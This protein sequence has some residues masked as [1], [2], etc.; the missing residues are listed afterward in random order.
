MIFN[1]RRIFGG[2]QTSGGVYVDIDFPV[3]I[4]TTGTNIPNINIFQGNIKAHQLA[5]NDYL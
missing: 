3:I 2:N 1:I 5:V 4:R